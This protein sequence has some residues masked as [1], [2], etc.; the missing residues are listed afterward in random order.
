MRNKASLVLMEQLIMLLVFALSAA[1]CLGI[2]AASHQISQRAVHQDNAVFLAQNAAEILKSN[3]GDLQKTARMLS[4]SVQE[5]ILTAEY[6][7]GYCIH[8]K[9]TCSSVSGLAKAS[10]WVTHDS[11]PEDAIFTLTVSW[12]EVG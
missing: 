4:A 12:Q 5:N 7:N 2:F 8:M 1:L 10:V 3:A 9:P 6:D 11:G